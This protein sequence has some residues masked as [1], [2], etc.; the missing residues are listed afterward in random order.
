ML[1]MAGSFGA[2]P[3]LSGQ[4]A[5]PVKR[6]SGEK[7]EPRRCQVRE[8]GGAVDAPSAGQRFRQDIAIVGGDRK[9]E[10]V[11][12][13]PRVQTRPTPQHT[14]AGDPAPEDELHAGAAVVGS[15]AAVGAEA[16]AKLAQH[17]DRRACVERGDVVP[18]RSKCTRQLSGQG[19]ETAR[20]AFVSVSAADID[21]GS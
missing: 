4:I 12:Q 13:L 20:L 9:V 19:V 5:W 7:A 18:E 1:L 6:R 17:H 10:A 8:C 14:A 2:A 15:V 16:P 3:A 11:L 21:C